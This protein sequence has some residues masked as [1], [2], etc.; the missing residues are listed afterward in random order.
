MAGMGG[1]QPDAP[2]VDED[3]AEPLPQYEMGGADDF[4]LRQAVR[5]LKGEKVESAPPAAATAA[6]PV[7][8]NPVGASGGAIIAPAPAGGTQK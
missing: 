3:V 6:A 5:F 4:Q 8:E 1:V 7:S 2:S